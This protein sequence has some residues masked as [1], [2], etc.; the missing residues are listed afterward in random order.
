M[1]FFHTSFSQ[2]SKKNPKEVGVQNFA[3][4]DELVKKNQKLLGNNVV[5]MVWTDTLVYK[6]ELG[7]FDSRTLAPIAS[8]SK[9]FTAALIMKLVEEEKISLDDKV[10]KYIPIFDTYGKSYITIRHCLTHFTGIQTDG[11]LFEKKKF[12]SLEDEV[13]SYAKKEIQTNPGTEFRY[14]D[15]GLNIAGRIAEIVSKKKFDMLIKQKLFNPLSMR[16]TTFGQLDGS[17]LNPSNGAQSTADEYLQFLKMLLNNGK[18]NGQ[19]FLS[20]ES[21]TELRKIYTTSATIQPGPRTT[22]GLGYALGSWV[23][24]EGKDGEATALASAAISGTWPMVNWCRGYA[25]LIITKNPS[26]EQK[27]EPYVELKGALDDKLHS[28]CK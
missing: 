9:W 18:H 7:E 23:I 14:S 22:E 26:G 19:Q 24:D 8:A 1:L 5:A 20:E 6:R 27:K 10:G 21:V 17:A 11:K 15:V 2:A 3:E 16:K 25:F 4:L 13:T 28:T 12:F